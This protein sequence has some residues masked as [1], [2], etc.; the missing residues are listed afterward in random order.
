M[1]ASKQTVIP[2]LPMKNLDE[3]DNLWLVAY[4]PEMDK[5]EETT[6]KN[7]ILHGIDMRARGREKGITKWLISAHDSFEDAHEHVLSLQK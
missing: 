6:L 7:V 1:K 4:Y 2:I 3:L 5:Y